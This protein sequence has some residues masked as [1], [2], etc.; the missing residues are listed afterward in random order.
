MQFLTSSI[1]F[2]ANLPQGTLLP[3][4]LAGENNLYVSVFAIF[5]FL[6]QLIETGLVWSQALVGLWAYVWELA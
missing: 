6:L 5:K 4:N 3:K 2:S 1:F